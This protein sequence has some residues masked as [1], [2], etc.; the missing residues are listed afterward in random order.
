MSSLRVFR[1]AALHHY[2]EVP[3]SDFPTPCSEVPAP[4]SLLPAPSKH[5][6]HRIENFYSQLF[7]NYLGR[8]F[9]PSLC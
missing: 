9:Y 7:F 4:K 8:F 3:S 6:P 1:D 2:S 5:V